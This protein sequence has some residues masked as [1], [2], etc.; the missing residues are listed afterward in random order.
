MYKNLKQNPKKER[1]L[2]NTSR[3]NNKERKIIFS[4]SYLHQKQNFILS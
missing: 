2:F 3:H 1:P 4:L